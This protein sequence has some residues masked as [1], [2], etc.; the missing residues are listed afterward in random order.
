MAR[1]PAVLPA[2]SISTIKYDSNL[3]KADRFIGHNFTQKPTKNTNVI[4][5]NLN[6]L[7]AA[8]PQSISI[9]LTIFALLF[10]FG[11]WLLNNKSLKD[12]NEIINQNFSDDETINDHPDNVV[13]FKENPQEV[14]EATDHKKAS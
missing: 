2:R 10:P 4:N 14:E 1:Q 6:R 8:G 7:S 11:L 12:E 5:Q 9:Y 3:P 13:E